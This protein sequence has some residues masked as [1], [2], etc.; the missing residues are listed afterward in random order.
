ME[1]IFPTDP[2]IAGL[3]LVGLH[4]SAAN[5]VTRAGTV[6][7]KR[8]YDIVPD[9]TDPARGR[10][11]PTEEALPVFLKDQPETLIVN[12]D[13]EAGVENWTAGASLTI[14]QEVDAEEN[15]F[16]AVTGA[17]HGRVT[18]SPD[19]DIPLRGRAFFLSFKARAD[20]PTSIENVCLEAGGSQICSISDS[21]TTD[22]QKFE[23]DEPGIWPNT[24]GA[25]RFTLILRA[26]E[27]AGRTVY[28]DDVMLSHIQYEHDLAT[29]KPG[30]DVIVLPG[31]NLVPAEISLDGIACL[32]RPATNPGEL[33]IFGWERREVAPRK[34]EAAFPENL[35]AY[36]LD[37][38][39]PP[40]FRNSFFNGYRRIARTQISPNL[41]PY[42]SP[43]A[44]IRLVRTGSSNYAFTLAGEAL[45]ATYFVYSGKGLDQENRWQTHSVS[46]H[47]DTLVLEPDANRCYTV[48]RGVWEFDEHAEGNYR[49]LQVLLN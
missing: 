23:V 42:I 12:G 39:L 27:D 28:Y 5:R 6:I 43:A 47:L 29:D 4:K 46:L 11:T 1:T 3:F 26:A 45:T 35:D 32:R 40:G 33:T 8:T 48:W 34:G 10:V 13:F 38:P 19:L 31:R 16:L 22:W 2:G 18:Q 36:P 30:A 25:T 41:V 17:I 24:I 21:L 44:A 20:A 7:V 9:D 49:R 37:P 14:R 15:H